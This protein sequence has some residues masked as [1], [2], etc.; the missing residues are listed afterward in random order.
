MSADAKVVTEERRKA[1]QPSVEDLEGTPLDPAGVP[2][3]AP[4]LFSAQVVDNAFC[5][6]VVDGRKFSLSGDELHN[7]RMTVDAAAVELVR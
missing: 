3:A 2:V 4:K 5:E 6:L 1:S 7:L